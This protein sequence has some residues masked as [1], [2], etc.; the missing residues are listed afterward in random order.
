MAADNEHEWLDVVNK[1]NVIVGRERRGIVHRDGLM[2]RAVYVLVFDT[3]RRLLLQRRS[4]E[5]KIGPGKWDLSCAEHLQVGESYR[6]AAFRGATEELG[7]TLSDCMA[8]V[9]P[10]KLQCLRYPAK[11]VKDFEFIEIYAA[12]TDAVP[13]PDPVEVAEVCFWSLDSLERAVQE[14]PDAFTDWFCLSL[15]DLSLRELAATTVTGAPV[16]AKVG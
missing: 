11:N 6:H 1:E 10:A 5:K 12:C 2:H 4:P 15:R 3:S 13:K 8:C 7:M 16:L 14:Q 9:R